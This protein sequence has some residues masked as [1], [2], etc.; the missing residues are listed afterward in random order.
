MGEKIAAGAAIALLIIMFIGWFGID[1]DSVA[2]LSRDDLEA[3]GEQF[4]N[5]GGSSDSFSANAWE[6]FGFI[7]II[8]L[9]TIIAAVALAAIS[10][11]ATRVNLPVA[12]SAVVAGLGI[13]STLLVL[14]RIIDTPFGFGR[15]VGVFLGLLA[16]AGIAY[17]GWRAM[18]EE[19]TSFQGEANRVQSDRGT[20]HDRGTGPGAGSPPPPPPSG[21]AA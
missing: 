18:Q 6:S 8:L 7:D 9:V 4:A 15:E 1:T 10:A 19:G 20:G 16:A 13:L 11:S 17:G 12:L 3:A 2:D 5:A 14:Y 21:P